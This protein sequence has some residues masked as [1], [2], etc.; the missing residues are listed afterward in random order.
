MKLS[1]FLNIS[2][3]H[4]EFKPNKNEKNNNHYYF[5]SQCPAVEFL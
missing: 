1:I 3:F 2:Y 5:V 4:T